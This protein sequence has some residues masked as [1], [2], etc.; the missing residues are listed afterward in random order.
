MPKL[1]GPLFSKKASGKFANAVVYSSWRGISYAKQYRR[2]RPRNSLRKQRVSG[3]FGRQ[4]KRW[5]VISEA[6][7]QAWERFA[8]EIG[9]KGTALTVFTAYSALALDAGLPEPLMPPR[10][11]KLLS[12]RLALRLDPAAKTLFLSWKTHRV[13]ADALVDL[14]F[15]SAKATHHP[16]PRFHHHLAFVPAL[17]QGYPVKDLLPNRRY[18]FRARLLLPDSSHSPFSSAAVLFEP[19]I[20]R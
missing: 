2:I 19:A 10:P 9:A 16:P 20:G 14:Y 13:P 6:N 15:C 4:A 12:P 18:S 7:R 8:R 1:G 17:L 11:R 5:S 3:L